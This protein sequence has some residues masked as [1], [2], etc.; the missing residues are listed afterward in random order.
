MA[1]L[2]AAVYY[3]LYTSSVAY[4]RAAHC[5]WRGMH[6][7]YE[8]PRYRGPLAGS[9]GLETSGSCHRDLGFGK[10]VMPGCPGP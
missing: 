1:R 5:A 6:M 10:V 2:Q 8:S 4:L 3:I 9:A 7:A